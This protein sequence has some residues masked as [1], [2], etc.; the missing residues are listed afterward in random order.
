MT[1]K[2][3]LE[4]TAVVSLPAVGG[5]G[6]RAGATMLDERQRKQAETQNRDLPAVDK[7]PAL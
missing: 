4:T 3:F 6:F 1:P 5:A 2:Q 7:K